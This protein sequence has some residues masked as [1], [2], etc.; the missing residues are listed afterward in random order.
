MVLAAIG[1][2]GSIPYELTHFNENNNKCNDKINNMIMY[3]N[4]GHKQLVQ[5]FNGEQL[6]GSKFVY[7]IFIKVKIL[8][9]I[10]S[11]FFT[12][13]LQWKISDLSIVFTN[14]PTS[15]VYTIKSCFI[16]STK[17]CPKPTF[18]TI[19]FFLSCF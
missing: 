9:Q 2:I 1:Q 16:T 15:F 12:W 6:P 8:L 18:E 19:H 13:L 3:F 17:Q 7:W 14:T 4:S 10:L 11:T 5:N